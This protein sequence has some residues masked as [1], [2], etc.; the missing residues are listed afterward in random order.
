MHTEKK[1]AYLLK[2]IVIDNILIGWT[3]LKESIEPVHVMHVSPQM[4]HAFRNLEVGEILASNANMLKSW[5]KLAVET[6]H[7]VTGEETRSLATKM[8]VNLA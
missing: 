3:A 8:F 6:A 7:R 1:K 4:N 2:L 5:H